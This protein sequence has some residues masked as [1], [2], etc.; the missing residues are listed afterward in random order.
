MPI[1]ASSAGGCS[2]ARP[3]G[4]P[5]A[6]RISRTVSSVWSFLLHHLNNSLITNIIEVG[7]EFAGTIPN[8]RPLHFDPVL[9]SPEI[10]CFVNCEKSP[11][12]LGS[13]GDSRRVAS[14]RLVIKT[15]VERPNL[16]EGVGRHVDLH[17]HTFVHR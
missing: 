8:V 5:V 9:G 12:D 1:S 17:V 15:S 14:A 13:V 2:M 4:I 3:S 10:L 11:M 6:D 7:P 16:V